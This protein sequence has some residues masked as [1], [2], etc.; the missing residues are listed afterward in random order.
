MLLNASF[1]KHAASEN[2]VPAG[3]NSWR[4]ISISI[5]YYAFWL[6]SLHVS[7]SFNTTIYYFEDI[8]G[9]FGIF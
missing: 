1:N 6:S 4:K 9:H 8:I 7:L 5:Q 2:V 3:T